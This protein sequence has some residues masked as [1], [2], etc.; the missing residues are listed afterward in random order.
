MIYYLETSAVYALN[1]YLVRDNGVA[2]AVCYS[3]FL[4]VFELLSGMTERTYERRKAILKNL[5]DSHISIDW[6]TPRELMAEAFGQVMLLDKWK[7]K[8]HR[9]ALIVSE[10]KD[11]MSAVKI[12]EEDNTSLS[13]SDAANADEILSTRHSL[14]VQEKIQQMRRQVPETEIRK[15]SEQLLTDPSAK[16]GLRTENVTALFWDLAVHVATNMPGVDPVE[17]LRRVAISYTGSANKFLFAD[18]V[19]QE[20]SLLSGETPGKNDFIDI[21]HLLYLKSPAQYLIT[22]DKLL[23]DI[24]AELFSECV[25]SVEDLRIKLCWTE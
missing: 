9:L 1:G 21:S 17:S 7:Q 19:R 10:S 23:L 5:L 3:S 24:C 15:I 12:S 13:I 18:A 25:F 14:E 8:V 11:F 2:K 20:R 6:D 22:N 4:S 16:R